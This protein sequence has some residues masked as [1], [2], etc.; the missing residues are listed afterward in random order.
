VKGDQIVSILGASHELHRMKDLKKWGAPREFVN[1]DLGRLSTDKYPCIYL[2]NPSDSPARKSAY[3][4]SIDCFNLVAE[5]E[6]KSN[7]YSADAD[8]RILGEAALVRIGEYRKTDAAFN[9]AAYSWVTEHVSPALQREIA[10]DRLR[11][12]GP[13]DSAPP[14]IVSVCKGCKLPVGITPPKLIHHV[15][16][17]YSDA[18]WERRIQGMSVISLV[19]DAQGLPQDVRTIIPMGYGIDELALAAVQQYRFKPAMMDGRVVRFG[20]TVEVDFHIAP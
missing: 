1:S 17:R 4:V 14:P 19:V 6:T 12:P 5:K 7:I 8:G 9:H 16:V 3:D 15:S 20:T 11:L 18:G 10:S 13:S 2:A